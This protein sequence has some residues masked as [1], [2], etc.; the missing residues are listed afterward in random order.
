M[1]P[2]PASRRGGAAG[3]R[4]ASDAR[5]ASGGGA[6]ALL[7]AALDA[8]LHG[9]HSL[10]TSRGDIK[11]TRVASSGLQTP[12]ATPAAAVWRVGQLRGC[13]ITGV[14]EPRLLGRLAAL[15]ARG[16]SCERPTGAGVATA[17]ILGTRNAPYV[18]T[19]VT[20]QRQASNWGGTQHLVNRPSSEEQRPPRKAADR[21]QDCREHCDHRIPRSRSSLHWCQPVSV[22]HKEAGNHILR[23]LRSCMSLLPPP[24]G[25]GLLSG[26]LAHLRSLW[27]SSGQ[28][29][30]HGQHAEQ[31][32]SILDE[33]PGEQGA[34]EGPANEDQAQQRLYG[35]AQPARTSG[36]ACP[37]HWPPCRPLPPARCRLPLPPDPT[38]LPLPQRSMRG[39]CVPRRRPRPMPAAC[40][41]RRSS[42]P[43]ENAHSGGGM[44]RLPGGRGGRSTVAMQLLAFCG[45]APHPCT[46]DDPLACPKCVQPNRRYLSQKEQDTGALL[47][48]AQQLQ[49]LMAQMAAATGGD[50]AA[51]AAVAEMGRL[52]EELGV[53]AAEARASAAQLKAETERGK[54]SSSQVGAVRWGG[55]L[56]G[57]GL[58]GV[59]GGCLGC[60]LCHAPAAAGHTAAA[61]APPTSSPHAPNSANKPGTANPCQLP[62]LHTIH[63]CCMPVC[64][65]DWRPKQACCGH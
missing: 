29:T 38:R 32:N 57:A 52:V 19:R 50:A 28:A 6:A 41:W 12:V 26:V 39:G 47:S 24:R 22:P 14:C 7:P 25:P 10:H 59:R 65:L 3:W 21:S 37:A 15:Q 62:G 43:S 45:H 51:S 23:I 8:R 20:W 55:V 36:I 49:G 1:K 46:S 48:R 11:A 35:K 2:S 18:T 63:A 40:W 13:W 64:R 27:S 34:A 60:S 56:V 31:L 33:L 9:T 17:A 30:M 42:G 5:A 44:R 53:A 54:R 61:A 4:P 16:T 58:A